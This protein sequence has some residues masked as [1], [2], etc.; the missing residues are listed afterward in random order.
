MERPRINDYADPVLFLKQ[1]LEYRKSSDKS[2]SVM[3]AAKDLRKVSS[4]LVSLVL[5]KKRKITLDR[6]DEFAKLMALTAAEKMCFKNWLKQEDQP[7]EQKLLIQDLKKK[8]RKDLTIHL[9]NDWLNIYVKDAFRIEAVQKKPTLIYKE[10]GTIASK[11]RIDRSLQFLL[12]EG[13]LRKTMDGRIVIE[14]TLLTNESPPPGL[15]ISSFHKAALAIAKQNMDMF[16][17]NERFANTMVL[18]LSPERYQELIEMIREFSKSLQDFATVEKEYG[19]RL[20]QVL[21]NL[22]PT[23]GRVE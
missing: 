12:R 14:T 15:K 5:Q 9:L 10:L 11:K 17:A 6:A 1:M 4:S 3:T 16:D 22:S 7:E 20:Y 2:F 23:G 19:D 18:D 8:N 13:Y 21:I